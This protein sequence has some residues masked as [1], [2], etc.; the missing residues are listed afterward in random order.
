MV[1]ATAAVGVEAVS[2]D[3]AMVHLMFSWLVAD[4]GSTLI[5]MS[6]PTAPFLSESIKTLICQMP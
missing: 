4:Q 3:G 2:A 5:L 6:L 1:E